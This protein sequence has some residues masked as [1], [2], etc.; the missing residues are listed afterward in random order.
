MSN[1]K[2][3]DVG[4]NIAEK[5]AVIRNLADIFRGPFKPHLS[6]RWEKIHEL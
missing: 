5:V 1:N 4:M 3:S 6:C 2:I